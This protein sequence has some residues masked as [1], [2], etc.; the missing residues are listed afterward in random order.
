MAEK[1]VEEQVLA[2]ERLRPFR[3]LQVYIRLSLPIPRLQYPLSINRCSYQCSSHILCLW[4]IL[5]NEKRL[6]NLKLD[7][8]DKKRRAACS[9]HIVVVK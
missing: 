6:Y 5:S 3:I 9:S 7:K 2:M 8:K 1:G 4:R